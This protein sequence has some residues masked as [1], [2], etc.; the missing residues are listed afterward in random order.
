MDMDELP[1]ELNPSRG[2][3]ATANEMNLP[4][5]Y[6]YEER[7]VSFEWYA[8][9]RYQR[10]AEV[11]EGNPGFAVQD[12]VELQTDYL[13][14]PARRIVARLEGLRSPDSKLEQALR[15]LRGWDHVLAADS[16]PAALFEVWYRVYLRP[17]LLARA[18]AEVVPKEKRDEAVTMVTPVEDQAGDARVGL[19]LIENPEGR[20]GPESERESERSRD[21][22]LLSSLRLAFEHLERLL[23]ADVR[24]WEWGKLHHAFLAHPLSPLFDE[25]TR[26]RLNVGPAPR[27]GSG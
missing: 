21:E 10:I 23:G 2:W 6:P 5:D 14:V 24:L 12:S 20:L 19:D 8:P 1:V 22:A 18:V 4:E 13:S 7:K 9:Y 11:L 17:A 27:G 16:A 3:I 15:M 25:W 26:E